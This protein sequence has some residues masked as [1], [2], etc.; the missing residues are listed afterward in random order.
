[1]KVKALHDIVVGV[2]EY[3]VGEIFQCST[4]DGQSLIEQE[5]AVAVEEEDEA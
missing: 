5:L 4:E 3:K 1:M 2:E